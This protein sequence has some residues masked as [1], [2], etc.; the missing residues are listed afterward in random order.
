MTLAGGPDLKKSIVKILMILL[1]VLFVAGSLAMLSKSRPLWSG[2]LIPDSCRKND[3]DYSGITNI[4]ICGIMNENGASLAEMTALISINETAHEIG[5]M[6]LPGITFV[7]EDKVKY[8]RLS[9][10]FNW[11]TDSVPDGGAGALSE[12]ISTLFGQR[13]DH[14]LTFDMKVLPQVTDLLDGVQLEVAEELKFEDRTLEAG[15]HEFGSKE[16]LRY[17]LSDSRE[18]VSSVSSIRQAFAE[19]VLNRLIKLPRT[20]TWSLLLKCRNGIDTDLSVKEIIEMKRSFDEVADGSVSFFTIPG[21][22]YTG[23]GTEKLSVWSV[24]RSAA[25]EMINTVLRKYNKKI[26]IEDLL[27]PELSF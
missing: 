21:T 10:A 26:I 12:C 3:I 25:I 9:G 5:I 24:D 17:I 18:N 22:V 15:Q 16:V 13:V 8:G 7:G 6:Y 1:S 4:I 14:Y 2:T 19:V 20:E 11:G 23:Y 27:I